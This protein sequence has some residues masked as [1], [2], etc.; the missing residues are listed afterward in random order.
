MNYPRTLTGCL[1]G[2]TMATSVA[3][4]VAP[5]RVQRAPASP[6]P[7]NVLLLVIDDIGPDMLGVYGTGTD[8]APTP[9]MDALARTGVLFRSA[10]SH[11]AGSVTMA[12]IETGRIGE[13]TGVGFTIY[14]G[15]GDPPLPLSEVILPELLD[16]AMPGVYDHAMIGKWFLGAD[17]SVGDELGPNTMGYGHYEGVIGQLY[18]GG[19]DYFNYPWVTNGVV[20]E[21]TGYVTTETVDAALG[22]IASASEPWLCHVA[23]NSAHTPY[24]KPPD[25]LHTQNIGPSP[26]PHG[27]AR[28]WYKAMVEALDTEIG[29]LLNSVDP[30]T[31]ADTTV[32]LLAD[33]GTPKGTVAPPFLPEH[34]KLTVYEGG[35][36]VPL[37]V[38]GHAVTAPGTEAHGLVGTTDIYATVAELAGIELAQLLPDLEH[39]SISIVPYFSNPA[40]RSLRELT[41]SELF[42]PNGFRQ[43]PTA[44]MYAS[45][46]VRYKLIRH[47]V[48]SGLV[49]EFYDLAND[50]LELNDLFLGAPSSPEALAA[51][52][53]LSAHIDAQLLLGP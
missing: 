52:N 29:R 28:P 38:S 49:E 41:F 36:K 6:P 44:Q 13:Q 14:N 30:V 26:P 8:L 48:G 7:G 15:P 45:R 50:P 23:F 34:G 11:P 43:P 53:K 4:Q 19:Y 42:Y 17:P 25:A 12:S 22:W 51:Y 9:N 5:P 35:V 16:L 46:D 31:L 33:N 27:D 1:L 37:I 2:I 47:K 32:I 21:R 40:Q 10:Y 18:L 39:Q 20:E 3:A 24:H